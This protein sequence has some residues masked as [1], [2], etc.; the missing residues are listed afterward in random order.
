MHQ[1]QIRYQGRVQGVGFR[2]TV[3]DISRNFDVVGMVQNRVDG[4]VRL[5]AEGEEKVLV[6]F[7]E[8]IRVRLSR[9]IVDEN[10]HWNAVQQASF[11][12]FTIGPTE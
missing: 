7:A 6:D 9:N 4:S 2:A 8:A 3:S 12:R 10:A 1:V 11:D 5:V